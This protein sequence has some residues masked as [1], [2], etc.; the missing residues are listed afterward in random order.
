MLVVCYLGGLGFAC[1]LSEQPLP[2]KPGMLFDPPASPMTC[3]WSPKGFYRCHVQL[4]VS[5]LKYKPVDSFPCHT[6][7]NQKRLKEQ[8]MWRAG[9]VIGNRC[10]KRK[11]NEKISN[12]KS[13]QKSTSNLWFTQFLIQILME[14]HGQKVVQ[15]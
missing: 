15:I 5:F 14:R 10:I 8:H 7:H 2:T 13:S 11:I 9:S 4:W 3:P 6:N 12:L 1:M